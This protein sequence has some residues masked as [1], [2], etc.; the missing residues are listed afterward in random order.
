MFT[1]RV[2]PSIVWPTETLIKLKA[3]IRLFLTIILFKLP[4]LQQNANSLCTNR[5]YQSKNLLSVAQS[6]SQVAIA[7]FQFYSSKI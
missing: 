3:E 7:D 6:Y 4:L 2:Q 1:I 5:K